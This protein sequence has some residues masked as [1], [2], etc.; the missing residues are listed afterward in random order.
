MN[1]KSI[2]VMGII[3]AL[4]GA[5]MIVGNM[6]VTVEDFEGNLTVDGNLNVTGSGEFGGDINMNHN[7]IIESDF[8]HWL[9]FT[10]EGG[11]TD[12]TLNIIPVGVCT[13]D[14]HYHRLTVGTSGSPGAGK[15]FNMT[16]TDGTNELTL[17]LTGAETIAWTETSEFDWDVS[18]ETLTLKYS[19]TAGGLVTNA[20]VTIKYHYKENE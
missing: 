10:V 5:F 17:S 11:K 13:Q 7:Y 18:T 19:Q 6:P 15:F 14:R 8:N 2:I 12:E 4:F 16:L 20:F 1:D 3:A 9:D